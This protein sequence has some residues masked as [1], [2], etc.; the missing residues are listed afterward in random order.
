MGIKEGWCRGRGTRGSFLA[1][2][3]GSVDGRGGSTRD[4]VGAESFE[5][6]RDVG[7]HR[8]GNGAAI[9][10]ELN[11]VAEVFGTGPVG[12]DVVEELEGGYEVFCV[13]F[14]DVFNTEVV[15]D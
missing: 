2:C 1:I 8:K 15:N 10:R 12:F 5:D 4:A 9:I 13:G 3:W 7:G 6:A 14:V 11:G